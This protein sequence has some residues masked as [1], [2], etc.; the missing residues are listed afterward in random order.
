MSSDQQQLAG[1]LASLQILVGLARLLEGIPSADPHLEP[2][3]FR[4]SSPNFQEPRYPRIRALAGELSD[5]ASAA[6]R[7]VSDLAIAWLLAH[8][9]SGAIVGVR[10]EKEARQ[11]ARA[12]R[13][14]PSDDVIASVD[15]AIARLDGSPTAPA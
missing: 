7:S 4:R 13:W 6:G 9:V 3:D 11:L 10:S 15:A 5:I 14:R 2:N 1:C 12:A 8:G